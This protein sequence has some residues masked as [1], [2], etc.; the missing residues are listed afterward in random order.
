MGRPAISLTVNY[1]VIDSLPYSSITGLSLLRKLKQWGVDNERN[2]VKFNDAY[3]PVSSEP[4]SCNGITLIVPK[5]CALAAN[6]YTLI[7]SK[8]KSPG[9]SASRPVTNLS[10]VTKGNPD[11]Q[12]R[13]GHAIQPSI[14]IS[15][16]NDSVPIRVINTNSVNKKVGKGIKLASGLNSFIELSTE[17]QNSVLYLK[18]AESPHDPIE[19]EMSHLSKEQIKEAKEI[20]ENYRDVFTVSNTKIGRTICMNFNINTD[21][22]SP[23][24]TSL[25]RVSLHQQ[26]I[27][28]KLLDH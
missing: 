5:R 23:V 1:V 13:L 7:Q 24:S 26:E 16:P 9:L 28:K 8:V 15:E 17:I 20:L 4:P 27:V 10:I 6:Q 14:H 3:I 11:L 21:H 18:D 12:H 2:L 25:R 19:I 22:V